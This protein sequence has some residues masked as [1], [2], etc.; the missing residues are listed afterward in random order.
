PSSA[1]HRGEHLDGERRLPLKH[2]A[3]QFSRQHRPRRAGGRSRSH[4]GAAERPPGRSRPRLSG[5]RAARGSLSRARAT[6]QRRRHAPLRIQHH[7]RQGAH[8]PRGCP[9]HRRLPAGTPTRI[10]RQSGRAR[11]TRPR[12]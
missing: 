9:G 7:H 4:R 10:R 11:Q 6:S 1:A 3:R 8:V 2:E 5:H 12:V